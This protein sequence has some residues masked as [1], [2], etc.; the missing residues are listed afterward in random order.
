MK[1]LALASEERA[2]L[3]KMVFLKRPNALDAAEMRCSTSKSSDRD[4]QM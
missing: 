3:A 2:L 1:A 4:S